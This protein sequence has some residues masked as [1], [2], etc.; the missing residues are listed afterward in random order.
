[1]YDPAPFE[2]AF[3]IVEIDCEIDVAK[4]QCEGATDVNLWRNISAYIEWLK[5]RKKEL[6]TAK[7][8]TQTHTRVTKRVIEGQ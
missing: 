7:V 5:V 2:L 3:T 4:R 6:E 8:D 1:M